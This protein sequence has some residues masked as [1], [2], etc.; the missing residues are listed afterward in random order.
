MLLPE[1]EFLIPSTIGEA[2]QAAGNDGTVFLAGGTSTA[3]LYKSRLIDPS[4]VIWLGGI[5]ELKGF[6]VLEAG[7]RIGAMTTMFE[8][9]SSK[10]LASGYSAIVSAAKAVGNARVRAMATV[11]GALAHADPRQDLPPA[12]IALGARVMV[13][14]MKSMREV[15]LERFYEGFLET[16][17]AP[18]ELITYVTVPY[19]PR[20][21]SSYLRFTPTS[22]GDFP[23]VGVG[24]S[25]TFAEDYK[26]IIDSKIVLCGV[27]QIP[28]VASKAA[29]LLV[30]TNGEDALLRSVARAVK[31]EVFPHDDERGSASYKT[32]MSEVWAY[33]ALLASRGQL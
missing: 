13:Q 12:L 22:E 31:D 20:R 18:G 28:A 14:G 4:T 23:T 26:T 19:M 15:P 21:T 32:E 6:H 7:L 1:T 17:L 8:I 33:R 5:S 30:G 27:G 10:D 3:L 25:L 16:V 24:A 11:G 2:L 9:A 29:S